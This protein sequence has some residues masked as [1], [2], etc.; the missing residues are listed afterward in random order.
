MNKKVRR[1]LNQTTQEL[2][3]KGC[4]QKWLDL[5]PQLA[6]MINRWTKEATNAPRCL[7]KRF[8]NPLAKIGKVATTI[9][10]CN[11]YIPSCQCREK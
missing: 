10:T 8:S 5:F 1:S 9:T 4:V 2:D 7:D 3:P 6:R 11:N